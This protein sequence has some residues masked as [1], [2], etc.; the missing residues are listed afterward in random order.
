MQ[1]Q[2]LIIGGG[3]TG[4]GLARDLALRGVH[5]VVAEMGDIN[6]GA[7]GGN[8]GLL[9]SGGRYVSSD[10]HSAAECREESDILR[11]LAP[12]CIEDTG[13]FF[14]A[15]KGDDES[16][17]ADFPLACANAGVPCEP[18]DLARAHEMEPHLS[19]DAIAVYAVHDASVD[20]FRL[21]LE[22]LT[23]ARDLGSIYMRRHRAVRFDIDDGKIRS[24]LFRHVRTGKEVLVEP[25]IVVS[26]AGAWCG[27][28]AALAGAHIPLRYSKGTLLV[29]HERLSH[30]VINRLRPP[31]NGDILVPGGT[32][33]VLGTTSVRLDTLDEIRPSMAEVDENIEEG[34]GMMPILGTTRYIRAYAGVRPLI[35]SGGESS[36][37]NASRGFQIFDHARSGITNFMTVAGGKL[38]TYRLMAEKA[39][40]VVCEHLGVDAPCLTRTEALPS[41]RRCQWTEPGLTP[42]EWL[43]AHAH[44]D[45]LLCECE[46]VPKSTVDTIVSSCQEYASEPAL[47]A[48]GL[49]SRVGKGACQGAFCGIRVGSYLYDEGVFQSETGLQRMREFFGERFK[50]QRSVLWGTQLAQAELAE[51]VHCGLMGLDNFEDRGG[52]S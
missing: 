3:V 34:Q 22:N 17:I 9:H 14:V 41:T 44:G 1:T 48:I 37:R 4:T 38:T 39:A 23:Q 51:A 52:T 28:I 8:H 43:T 30:R 20:P 10:P 50:G 46:M 6:A 27:E 31:G 26:A 29:T 32:V 40:D 35:E 36:D 18:V 13:G 45:E 2:V 33:S 5:C 7:S 42:K 47:R 24:V 19:P 16:Y 25:E 12:Q 21:S 15:V 11:R 49:R